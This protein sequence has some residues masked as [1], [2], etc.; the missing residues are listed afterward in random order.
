[1]KARRALAALW[2]VRAA[3]GVNDYKHANTARMSEY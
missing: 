1:M 2:G 3:G